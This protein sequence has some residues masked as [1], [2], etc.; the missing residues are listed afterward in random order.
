MR[1][2]IIEKNDSRM[3]F[4]VEET[5]TGIANALRRIM[6]GE[7][8]VMAVEHVDVEQNNS[9]LYDEMLC[10][11]IG[12]IPLTFDRESYVQKKNCKCDGAGCS[13]CEVVLVLDKTGPCI[14]K[15]GDMKSTDES[16]RPADPDTIIVELLEGQA[17]KLEATAIL[18]IGKNHAKWQPASAGYRYAP[19][20]RINS[21]KCDACGKCVSLCP[22]NILQKKEGK[23]GTSNVINC[24][25]CMR[26]AE[27]CDSGAISISPSETSF[28]FTVETTSSLKPE[29]VVQAALDVLE[30]RASEFIDEFKKA[31]KS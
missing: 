5:D 20:V 2:K 10:H 19:A 31:V 8:P 22:K 15:A 27:R 16:V 7:V 26:C 4:V 1:V 9:G 12:L 24:D 6:I 17:V 3:V 13:R 30:E 28:I 14:V 21:E 25:S 29:D 11:R 18:G 23:I